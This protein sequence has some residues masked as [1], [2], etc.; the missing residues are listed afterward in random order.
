M[1]ISVK[2]TISINC[3]SLNTI[4][5][6][7]N[8]SCECRGEGGNPP[9]KINWYKDDLQIGGTGREKQTLN[10]SH[11]DHKASGTYKC[12]ARSYTLAVIESI[13]LIVYCK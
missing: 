5:E 13:K 6:G 10:L 7:D 2:P 9:A 3:S 8:F 12:E 11:V 1:F 4:N